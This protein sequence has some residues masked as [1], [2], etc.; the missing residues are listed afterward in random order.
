MSYQPTLSVL[1]R[2]LDDYPDRMD[3][4]RVLDAQ[5]RLT[6]RDTIRRD[7]E[8]LLNA[9]RPWVTTAPHHDA[10]KQSPL[11]Y[12]LVDVTASVLSN[13]DE[14]E[15]IRTDVETVIALFEPR[16]S[17]VRVS[18]LPDEA[19]LSAVIPLHVE[20]VLLVTSEPEYIRYST[21]ILP[22]S[23]SVSVQSVQEG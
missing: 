4:R 17:A 6:L 23:S 21:A 2:L 8:A 5:A 1:D 3:D 15:R 20:A 18:L 14:R 13:A 12:G 9:T 10:L 22:S 19:P 11:G 7:L 16:L